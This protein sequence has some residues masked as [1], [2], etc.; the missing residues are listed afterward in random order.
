MSV[1]AVAA[2]AATSPGAL[3]HYFA[4]QEELLGLALTTVIERVEARLV[5]GL[6]GLDGTAAARAILEQFLPLDEERQAETEVYLAFIGRAHTDAA[7]RP[8]RDDA[9]E[10][11]RGAIRQAMG[12][13][14]DAGTLAPGRDPELE[15]SRTFA[16][17]DGLAMHG[18]LLPDRHPRHELIRVLDLHL[19]E[20]GSP[21]SVPAAV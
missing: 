14:A 18:A 17:L 8:L 21:P 9:D 12:L 3:R 7:L 5:N 16:L 15:A 1:R 6:E 2:E 10:R 11:A 20:L 19:A 4:S 13:L